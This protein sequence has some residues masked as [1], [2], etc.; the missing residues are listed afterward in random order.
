MYS[1]SFTSL[2]ADNLPSWLPPF[3]H[4]MYQAIPEEKLGKSQTLLLNR[5]PE[6]QTILLKQEEPKYSM[7]MDLSLEQKGVNLNLRAEVS[8]EAITVM[9]D[10][11]WNELHP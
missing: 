2:T 4:A 11:E 8:G 1:I 5:T 7:A 3:L 6:G 10:E 9:C